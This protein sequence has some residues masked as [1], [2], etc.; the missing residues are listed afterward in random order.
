MR[1]TR[2]PPGAL[3]RKLQRI[4]LG[5]VHL[6][7]QAHGSAGKTAD[8]GAVLP[9]HLMADRIGPDRRAILD[10]EARDRP[11]VLIRDTDPKESLGGHVDHELPAGEDE[12][13]RRS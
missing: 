12:R 9:L 13:T 11:A 5:F 8:V 1:E 3:V 6:E 10:R 2:A 4:K 7:E